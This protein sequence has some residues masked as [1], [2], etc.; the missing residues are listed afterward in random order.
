MLANHKRV[1]R[2]MREDNLLAMQPRQFIV[3]THLDHPL[4]VYLN[5][6]RRMKLD[7]NRST[8]GGRHHLHSAASRVRLP[9]IGSGPFIEH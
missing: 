4:E 3:T 7:G 6:A 9:G 8:L 5:L 2:I 1:A